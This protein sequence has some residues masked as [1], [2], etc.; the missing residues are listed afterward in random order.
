MFHFLKDMVTTLE[1]YFD[2]RGGSWKAPPTQV[3]F[4]SPLLTRTPVC[5]WPL[6]VCQASRSV[7]SLHLGFCHM[8]TSQV[9]PHHPHSSFS[10]Q[11]C[12]VSDP[13]P[14]AMTPSHLVSAFDLAPSRSSVGQR[15]VSVWYAWMLCVLFKLFCLMLQRT[16]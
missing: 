3:P 8:E 5:G 2:K 9:P 12:P 1:E 7:S 16:L 13:T 6:A 10:N 15:L 4:P 11:A 14:F